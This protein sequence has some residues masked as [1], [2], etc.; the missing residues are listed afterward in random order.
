MFQSVA[1]DVSHYSCVPVGHSVTCCTSTVLMTSIRHDKVP[2]STGVHIR[3]SFLKTISTHLL[4]VV[5]SQNIEQNIH[6]MAL[7][8]CSVINSIK[9]PNISSAFCRFWHVK[10]LW[11]MPIKIYIVMTIGGFF[12]LHA[13]DL[14]FTLVD[15]EFS[16]WG[17]LRCV[18]PT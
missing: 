4:T 1:P 8:F 2:P 13:Y 17:I 3:P 15:I 7:N 16:Q 11:G 10:W 6:D 5:I 18:F 9:N 12:C 14:N